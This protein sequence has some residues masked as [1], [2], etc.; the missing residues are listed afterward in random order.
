[1]LL[2]PNGQPIENGQLKQIVEQNPQFTTRKITDI[3]NASKSTISRCLKKLVTLA[4]SMC[5]FHPIDRS[6][7]EP[8]DFNMRFVAKKA[9]KKPIFVKNLTNGGENWIVYNNIKRKRS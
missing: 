7:A 4:R 1:M 8:P 3:V 5:G 9:K 2:A 6:P